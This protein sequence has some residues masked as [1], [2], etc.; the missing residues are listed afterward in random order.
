[1][2]VAFKSGDEKTLQCW[3]T[4]RDGGSIPND[5]LIPDVVFSSLRLLLRYGEWGAC[6]LYS[7]ASHR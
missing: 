6:A 5:A 2:T 4:V 7:S 3:L 1:M